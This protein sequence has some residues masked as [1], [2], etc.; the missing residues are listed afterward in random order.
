MYSAIRKSS[1]DILPFIDFSSGTVRFFKTF[2]ISLAGQFGSFI[3]LYK[4]SGIDPE[5]DSC[6]TQK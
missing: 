6:P 1:S 3:F 5:S 4:D 2:S